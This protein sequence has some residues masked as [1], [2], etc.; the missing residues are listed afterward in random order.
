M[1]SFKAISTVSFFVFVQA[2]RI[3]SSIRLLSISMLVRN[4]ITSYTIIHEI[5][6]I[7]KVLASPRY[8]GACLFL[9]PQPA[10]RLGEIL[11]RT[12]LEGFPLQ[13]S[14]PDLDR[15]FSHLDRQI[16][17]PSFSIILP[18]F[19]IIT[20]GLIVGSGL[21]AGIT[22]VTLLWRL[23]PALSWQA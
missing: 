15:L 10:A 16:N 2:K 17:R 14:Y 13:H 3:A 11:E 7:F 20:A 22:G 9:R 19:I 4:F 12:D 8:P 5:I 6:H 18:A 1:S 21:V 23:K